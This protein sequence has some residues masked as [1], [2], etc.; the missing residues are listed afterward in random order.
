M[1]PH[2]ESDLGFALPPPARISRARALAIGASIL[3]VLAAAFVIRWLPNRHARQALEADARGQ[4][5]IT[6]RVQIVVP[7]A[8]SSDRALALPG[9]IQPLEETVV[10]PRASG[11]V[12]KWHHDLGDK[13]AEGDL[14]AEID[15]PELDQQIA[16]ARAQLAQAEAGLVQAKA[17]GHFS[18]ENLDRYK[19][20]GSEGLVSQQDL[21]KQKAQAEVDEAS[22]SVSNANIG[23]QRANI[24]LLTQ[25]KSFARVTA[26]FAGTITARSVERGALVTAGTATPL[27]KLSATDTVRVFVQVPQDVAP[28]V[29]TEVAASVK[30]REFAGRSFEGKVSRAAGALD[31]TTRTMTTEVRVPNPKG[32]LIT[33]MYA[34]V[35]L[36]LPTPHRVLS[37]PATALLNDATGLHV[38]VVGA[39]ERV[40]HVPVVVE[41]DTGPTVE[42]ASGLAPDDRVVKLPSVDLLEGRLVEI[43]R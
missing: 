35:S 29:R 19:Q 5:A 39:G 16:Q 3:S 20:L 2:A 7:T 28:S 11:Y 30:I 37:V 31:A 33:G 14:L 34:Q 41:R 32:E 9:S 4:E 21:A 36:T 8:V 12:R 27:F 38:V 17:N 6:P 25:M 24:Q 42:I 18:K 1:T 40:H 23:A 15:T 43:V 26:P 13:V 22:I 10:Y